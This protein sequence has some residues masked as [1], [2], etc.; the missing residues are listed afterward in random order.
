MLQFMSVSCLHF[1]YSLWIVICHLKMFL[2]LPNF[3]LV[4][5]FH[6]HTC[7]DFSSGQFIILAWTFVLPNQLYFLIDYC[8]LAVNRKLLI[9][10]NLLL[11]FIIEV[12]AK[13]KLCN[14]PIFFKSPI[15]S[16]LLFLPLPLL[17]C[18]YLLMACLF[19]HLA[20]SGY[21]MQT[22]QGLKLLGLYIERLC[23]YKN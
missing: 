16:N 9:T 13:L 21:L 23:H 5:P 11:P 15:I 3:I 6:S 22:W 2:P 8:W 10:L 4:Y 12:N 18:W 19:A 20:S 7:L 17:F 1:N 14:D